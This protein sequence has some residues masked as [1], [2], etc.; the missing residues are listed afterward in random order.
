MLARLSRAYAGSDAIAEQL[1][2]ELMQVKRADALAHAPSSI[3]N[4]MANLDNVER[5]FQQV[6]REGQTYRV[7]DLAIS[8][9]DVMAAGVP[10][11]PEVGHELRM[12]L[13]RVID[14]RLPN[15]RGALLDALAL[16][17]SSGSS[18]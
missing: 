9:A 8:G 2:G 7:R 1:F 11:G 12:L 15:E 4:R 3:P 14:G 5:I 16:D 10:R 13:T 18:R 17:V 6:V